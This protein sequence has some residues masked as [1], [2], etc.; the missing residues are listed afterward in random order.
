[1]QYNENQDVKSIQFERDKKIRADTESQNTFSWSSDGFV[2]SAITNANIEA[3][4]LC[5]EN[6]QFILF[7]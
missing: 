1:M 7:K 4:Q 3:C 6:S 5:P 2:Q